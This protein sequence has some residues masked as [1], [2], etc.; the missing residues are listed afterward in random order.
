MAVDALFFSAIS[1]ALRKETGRVPACSAAGCTEGVC[2]ES[3]ALNQRH[4]TAKIST[5]RPEF[6][7]PPAEQNECESE[8]LTGK[9]GQ[10]ILRGMEL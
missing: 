2:A 1:M 8:I 5:R 3:D 6:I 4:G 7:F 10:R 9:T